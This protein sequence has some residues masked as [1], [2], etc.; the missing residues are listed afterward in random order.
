MS[1]SKTVILL[2]ITGLS[3]CLMPRNNTSRATST[4]GDIQNA[5]KYGY[6]PID[7]LP[8]SLNF[9]ADS[10]VFVNKD[11]LNALPDETVRLAIGQFDA[12]GSL[13]FGPANAGVAG[14]NYVVVLDYIKFTTLPEKVRVSQSDSTGEKYFSVVSQQADAQ[15]IVPVYIGIGLRLT[16]NVTV[17]QGN[18]DL[19]NLIA[20]GIAAQT[21]K[22]TGTL[23]VQTLGISGEGISANIPMPSDI[24]Q[25]SIQNAIQ[26]LGSIKANIYNEKTLINP[27]VVGIYN[28]LG[29]GAVTVNRFI[30]KVL[31]EPIKLNITHRVF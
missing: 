2:L 20:L 23:V 14:K 22:I 5:P 25:T 13:S 16:A 29:G 28:N 11:L 12:K 10:S 19:G 31:E 24:N 18:V 30:S 9:P 7:P 4:Q 21:N 26:A 27:R 15:M 8:V 17:V 3:G 1:P 6:T